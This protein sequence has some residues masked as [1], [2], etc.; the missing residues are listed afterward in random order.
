MVLSTLLLKFSGTGKTE[1]SYISLDDLS[2][3]TILIFPNRVSFLLFQ[4][5]K[6]FFQIFQFLIKIKTFAFASIV[7]EMD[8]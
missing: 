6:I 1:A 2:D 4:E 3:L 7:G 8:T 5:L